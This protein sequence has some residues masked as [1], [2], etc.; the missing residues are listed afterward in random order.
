LERRFVFFS[1]SSRLAR[2]GLAAA[3]ALSI[4]APAAT[5]QAVVE[6]AWINYPTFAD[7]SSLELN[8]TADVVTT[9]GE[10]PQKVLRL[11]NGGYRQVGSA[12]SDD[13]VDL[14]ESF[15]TT[16][17]VYLHHEEST[18]PGADGIAFVIQTVGERA[19]G[20]WGGGMGYRYI[21]PSVA[22][23]F[24]TYQNT[25][26]PDN[27]HLAVVIGGNPDRHSATSNSPIPLYGRPFLAR[28][29]YD[30]A[31]SELTV[32]VKSLRAGA[33]ETRMLDY[34]IDLAWAFGRSAGWVGFTGAT[35]SVV[36]KQ[37]I[38]SW[39]LSGV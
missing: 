15:D 2:G 16:F 37:D 4:A 23:E 24:D 9:A 13:L 11:T 3:V 36:S 39:T 17:K 28:V 31:N 5:A 30:A 29:H 21:K 12:W 20:G 27:N 1:R 19:L 6:Q 26:D 14:T 8:G 35:G 34:D 25:N 33:V 38:Y 32:F 22:I 18:R 10:N 7:G